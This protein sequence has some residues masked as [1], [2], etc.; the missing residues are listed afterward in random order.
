MLWSILFFAAIIYLLGISTLLLAL[1]SRRMGVEVHVLS[2]GVG[3]AAFACL[4]VL[5]NTVGLPLVWWVFLASALVLLALAV[6]RCLLRRKRGQEPFACRPEGCCAQKAPVP[7]S[8]F[9][10]P[11]WTKDSLGLLVAAALA[12]VLAVVY[13][14]GALS[15]P[16]LEDDDSWVH[17]TSAEYVAVHHTYSISPEARAGVLSYLE[18]YPPAFPVLMGVLHQLN[19][20]VF[21]TLKLF[22]VL[23][24]SLGI[25]YFYLMAREWTGKPALALWMSGVL[26]V[27]PC[28]MSRFIW[29]QSLSLVL[30]FPAFYAMERARREPRWAVVLAILIAGMF[31]TQPSSAAIFAAMAGIS[32]LVKVVLALF[33]A[34]ERPARRYHLHLLAAG[35]AGL[36]LAAGFYLPAYLKF[37]RE[38][39]LYGVGRIQPVEGLSMKVAGTSIGRAYGISDFL[40]SDAFVNKINQPTGL[41]PVLFLVLSA[42]V[43]LLLVRPRRLKGSPWGVTAL[44]W[45]G[46]TVLGLEGDALPVSL[47]PHRFWAF[48]AVPAAMIAGES[49]SSLASDLDWKNVALAVGTGLTLATALIFGGVAEALQGV[50]PAGLE[51]LRL[52]IVLVAVLGC[53][54]GFAAGPLRL[55]GEKGTGAFCAQHP[56]GPTGKRLLSPFPVFRFFGLVLLLAGIL[57]TSGYPKAVFEGAIEWPSGVYFYV[58]TVSTDAGE[59]ALVQQHLDGYLE[60]RRTFPPD[61][62]VFC[63]TGSDDHVIGF[64][65]YSPP[66]DLEI[67]RFR[68]DLEGM[69]LKNID[70]R[71]VARIL[72]IAR[73]KEFQCVLLDFCWA[74][75]VQFDENSWT[76][77]LRRRREDAGL[78][79][80]RFEELFD[81]GAPPTDRE[82]PFLAS[83]RECLDRRRQLAQDE[84]LAVGKVRRL[85][86]LMSASPELKLVLDSGPFG[87]AVFALK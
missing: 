56:S 23:I 77:R 19:T 16:W 17:A 43:V 13:L 84:A 47:F 8:S 85:R 60:I 41:G 83:I 21:L 18:P 72:D 69:S 6:C 78:T 1:G 42:G 26:W 74:A 80:A 14:C 63:V 30:F 59:P 51:G 52:V 7:F 9:D 27:A 2:T 46:F 70:G 29:A 20:S 33:R 11:F 37:G 39:F 55:H 87:V 44:L 81:R 75:D 45:L 65:M 28:F 54:G 61:T 58:G 32:W 71:V 82:K 57:V 40:W 76:R 35:F 4:A 10:E 62:P 3:L 22:N 5:L 50:P 66:Y 36:V 64:D 73:R 38:G 31:L 48:L 34:G 53:L 24:V 25:L 15:T 12:A 79:D 68:K 67:K 86:Q 49:L